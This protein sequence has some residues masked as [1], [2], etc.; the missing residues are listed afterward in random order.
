MTKPFQL[1]QREEKAGS[2]KVMLEE[3]LADV[4]DIVRPENREE[5]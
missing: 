5:L 3:G 1:A 2:R 4:E